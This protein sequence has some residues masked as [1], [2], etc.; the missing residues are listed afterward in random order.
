[1]TLFFNL[2]DELIPQITN[3]IFDYIGSLGSMF[4]QSRETA[5]D[6]KI[7]SSRILERMETL[8]Y[9]NLGNIRHAFL[10]KGILEGAYKTER[11]V[12]TLDEKLV[13]GDLILDDYTENLL[14]NI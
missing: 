3:K 10:Q 12:E 7:R 2:F 11:C 1:M 9:D 14:P 5:N 8:G 4:Q 13:H 6:F